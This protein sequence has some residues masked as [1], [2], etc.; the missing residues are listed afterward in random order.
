MRGHDQGL[1][2]AGG[3]RKRVCDRVIGPCRHLG[4][5]Q[6]VAVDQISLHHRHAI[7]CRV[8]GTA[9]KQRA[10]LDAEEAWDLGPV[11]IQV[12][13]F[14]AGQ[15]QGE[16]REVVRAGGRVHRALHLLKPTV[17]GQAGGSCHHLAWGQGLGQVRDPAH[18]YRLADHLVENGVCRGLSQQPDF[19]K[20]AGHSAGRQGEAW[21]HAHGAS[22]GDRAVR[23]GLFERA[24]LNLVGHGGA[25][26]GIGHADT[27]EILGGVCELQDQAPV[28]G[29]VAMPVERTKMGATM[30]LVSVVL[31][32]VP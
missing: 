25:G 18:G 7:F 13:E 9:A 14:R 31:F 30:L 2:R 5:R 27:V 23:V 24:E 26:V 17:N 6:A 19:A 20:Q 11:G 10:V 1:E 4:L 28:T 3:A 32:R 12:L 16:K 22:A 8:A 15:R 29:S 21:G